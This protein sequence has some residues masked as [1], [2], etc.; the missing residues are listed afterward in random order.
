VVQVTRIGTQVVVRL[1]GPVCHCRTAELERAYL[2]VCELASTL[3]AID[4]EDAE[5][6]DRTGIDFVAR[7]HARWRLRLLNAPVGLR[8]QLVSA[9]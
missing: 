7:L 8:A 6:L 2:E 4:L 5:L 1:T 9:G 3:V